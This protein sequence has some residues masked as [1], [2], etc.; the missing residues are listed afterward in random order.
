MS[1]KE[2]L[3]LPPKPKTK[4]KNKGCPL[5]KKPEEYAAHTDDEEENVNDEEDEEA[6]EL[7]AGDQ[8]ATGEDEE[9]NN[10]VASLDSNRSNKSVRSRPSTP[11]I[12]LK[13][14]GQSGDESEEESEPS[15]SPK[16]TTPPLSKNKGGSR[17]A[18]PHVAKPPAR[19]AS[20]R[21]AKAKASAAKP[22]AK[23]PSKPKID[24]PTLKMSMLLR[25]QSRKT[26]VYSDTNQMPTQSLRNK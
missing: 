22:K 6:S 14:K 17:T 24:E 19:G 26:D 12:V 3:Q 20:Q 15:Q 11:G 25:S 18:R 2:A 21:V 1:S 4:S 5:S 9:A 10:E 23:T 13:N 7:N 16:K 8:K